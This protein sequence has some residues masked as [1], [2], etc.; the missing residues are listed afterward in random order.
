M[1]RFII[2]QH[3]LLAH[4]NGQHMQRKPNFL[5]ERKK[6]EVETSTYINIFYPYQTM[7]L[8]IKVIVHNKSTITRTFL[9]NLII[10]IQISKHN[11]TL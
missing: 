7:F 10:F 5:M 8:K 4:E 1:V 6:P 2:P 3:R 11:N 9:N